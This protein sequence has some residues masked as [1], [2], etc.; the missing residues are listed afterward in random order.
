[1]S[2]NGGSLTS[3]KFNQNDLRYQDDD[4]SEEKYKGRSRK[5]KCKK[6]SFR[7]NFRRSHGKFR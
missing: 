3:V 6:R 4:F 5:P 7:V 1:M 2:A